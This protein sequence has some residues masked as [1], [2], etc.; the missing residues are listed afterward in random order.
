MH[1]HAI[2]HTVDP[3]PI[4]VLLADDHH[5]TLWGLQQFLESVEPRIQV[6]GKA[7][8]A[9]ELMQHPAPGRPT[10][11]C[12]IWALATKQPRMLAPL[13]RNPTFKWLF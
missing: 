13:V 2:E 6:L 9:E 3:L 4:K 10:W 7:T 12:L 5:I 8:T 11:W 1:A